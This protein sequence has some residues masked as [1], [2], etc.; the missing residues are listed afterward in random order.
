MRQS[1]LYLFAVIAVTA[2]L[3]GCEHDDTPDG[4]SIED[5]FGEFRVDSAFT[6]SR[7]SVDF[8]AGETVVFSGGFNINVEWTI[9]IRGKESGAFRRIQGFGNT[10]TAQDATWNG[11][12]TNLPFFKVEPCEVIFKVDEQEAFADTLEIHVLGPRNYPGKVFADFEEPAPQDIELGNFEF[13]LTLPATGRTQDI[14]AAEGNHYF[15][16]AGTDDVVQNFFV[17]LIN[18]SSTITGDT[19]I[20]LPT[21]VPSQL[22][23]N[24]FVRHDNRPHT[25][26]VI[27]F[28]FDSND[29]GVFDDGIDATFQVD[30]DF[31]LNHNGWRHF[32]HPMSATGISA[33]QL[34][35]IVAIRVLLISDDNSQ[36]NPPLEVAFG[37]DYMT[38]TQ[39]GPLQ[40]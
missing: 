7:D 31:P 2:F 13:E 6:A 29:N 23:F 24:F 19:Y 4:P 16:M 38:F 18:I 28:A 10:L 8:S 27:Q 37:I 20:N 40:L 26:L 3:T 33:A 36:P 34:E 12:T 17:G 5:R 9:E 35:K 14:T 39:G 1:F 11:R 15:Y 32:H 30:G 22:Y 21:T 25:I